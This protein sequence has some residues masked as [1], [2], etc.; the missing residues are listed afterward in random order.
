MCFIVL[1]L[2]Y[3][4]M[5]WCLDFLLVLPGMVAILDLGIGISLMRS[6][7]SCVLHN[8]V[9]DSVDLGFRTFVYREIIRILDVEWGYPRD[10]GDI[11]AYTSHFALGSCIVDLELMLHGW[12]P[13]WTSDLEFW[14]YNRMLKILDP[15]L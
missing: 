2:L 13:S 10:P 1:L 14:S 7:G 8:F 5:Q 11:G 6:P 15:K 3:S 9:F 12:I 4:L